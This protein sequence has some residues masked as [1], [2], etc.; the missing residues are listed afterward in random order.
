MKRALVLVEGGTEER[1]VKD[2][3]R[4]SLATGTGPR[5]DPAH[6]QAGE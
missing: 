2:V 6:D 4:E 5:T 3:L 1:F